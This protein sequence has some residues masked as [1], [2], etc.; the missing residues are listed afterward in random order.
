VWPLERAVAAGADADTAVVVLDGYPSGTE[1]RAM[2]DV[3]TRRPQLSVLVVG[4]L[5]PDVDVLVA[6]ASGA[7]GYLPSNSSPVAIAAAV[8]ALLTGDAVL[9]RA[10]SSPLIQLLRRGGRGIVVRD[11]DG[12]TV[13]L[14]GREWEVLVLIRQACSTAEIASRFVVSNGTVRTHVAALTHKLGAQDRRSLAH[15]RNGDSF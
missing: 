15:S 9:P 8:D 11:V 13:E 2:S 1:L 10:V 6:L 14:T 5:E 7:F 12:R 3:T 4:P